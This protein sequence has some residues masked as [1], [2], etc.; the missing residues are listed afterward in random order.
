M[1]TIVDIPE[2]RIQAL[3]RIC[4]RHRISR[5]EAVRQAI[6]HYISIRRTEDSDEAFGLWKER[7]VDGLQYQQDVRAEWNQ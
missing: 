3:S 6:D 4:K 2:D 1:R 5:A 7:G